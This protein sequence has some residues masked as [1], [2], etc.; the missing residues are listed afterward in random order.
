M[1]LALKL[2]ERETGDRL[3][4]STVGGGDTSQLAVAERALQDLDMRLVA[5]PLAVD[6]EGES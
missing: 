4:S 6:W 1:N 5:G 3:G 2:A